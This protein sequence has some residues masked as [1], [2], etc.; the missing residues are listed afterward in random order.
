MMRALEEANPFYNATEQ[1]SDFVEMLHGKNVY[2][3]YK[4][5]VVVC[6]KD[7]SNF[8]HVKWINVTKDYNTLKTTLEECRGQKD[9]YININ[10]F[11]NFKRER[12]NVHQLKFLYADLDVE[13]YREKRKSYLSIE[14]TVVAIDYLVKDFKIPQ[15][16]ML[17]HTGRGLHAYWSIGDYVS[18]ATNNKFWEDIQLQLYNILKNLGADRAIVTDTSRVL[19]VPCTVNSKNGAV[20]K[21]LEYNS[22][23]IYSLEDIRNKYFKENLDKELQ[24]KKTKIKKSKIIKNNNIINLSKSKTLFTL[25]KSRLEDLIK[26]IK[27]REGKLEGNRNNILLQIS[28]YYAVTHKRATEEEVIEFAREINNLFQDKLKEKE[29]KSIVKNALKYS[30]QKLTE[31]ENNKVPRNTCLYCVSVSISKSLKAGLNYSTTTLID[32]YSITREE[33]QNLATLIDNEEK[34]RRQLEKERE[35][36]R[37]SEGLTAREQKKRDTYNSI[38]E[39]K[40]NGFTQKYV[41]TSL[42]LSLN[43][44]KRHWKTVE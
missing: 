13:N 37:N 5:C 39:L 42:Q 15:P 27:M 3:N 10:P 31:M 33:M 41:A 7:K 34:L 26:L 25:H 20:C 16:T 12:D 1:I 29:V 23:N 18:N 43:T 24:D 8:K 4:G 32:L 17:V 36:R 35:A 2:G 21:I 30:I 11:K 38:Q 44:V 19:R 22:N 28:Y 40:S 14:Q 9:I 6:K